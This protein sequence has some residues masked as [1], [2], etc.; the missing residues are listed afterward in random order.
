M[1][2][3][4]CMKQKMGLLGKKQGAGLL[5]PNIP[6]LERKTKENGCCVLGEESD[7]TT[8]ALA[9]VQYSDA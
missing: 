1:L 6:F 7:N 9:P 8:M 4:V 2:Q 3:V 5:L